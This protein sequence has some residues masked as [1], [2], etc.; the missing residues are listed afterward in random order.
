MCL[1]DNLQDAADCGGLGRIISTRSAASDRKAAETALSTAL[2]SLELEKDERNIGVHEV[3][4]RQLL[5]MLDKEH[6]AYVSKEGLDLQIDPEK[7][8]LKHFVDRVTRAVERKRSRFVPAQPTSLLGEALRDHAEA[9]ALAARLEGTR[10]D[11][12][13]LESASI[14]SSKWSGTW[15]PKWWSWRR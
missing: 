4:C 7:S 6:Q 11:M 10:D 9:E 8:Y 15:T 5:G 14:V 12:D 1:A 3:L 13:H 2:R